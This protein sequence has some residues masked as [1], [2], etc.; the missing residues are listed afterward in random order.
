MKCGGRRGIRTLGGGS[1]TSSDYKSDAL[2]RS[3]SLPVQPGNRDFCLKIGLP[4]RGGP[5]LLC[6]IHKMRGCC[7]PSQQ[8]YLISLPLTFVTRHESLIITISGYCRTAAIFP[9]YCHFPALLPFSRITANFL[10]CCLRSSLRQFFALPTLS[11]GVIIISP[12]CHFHCIACGFSDR[13][14]LSVHRCRITFINHQT[15]RG[16]AVHQSK[17]IY[18]FVA[19]SV[20]GGGAHL[21]VEPLSLKMSGFR[22]LV[23]R[24][25]CVVK[26]N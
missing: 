22:T 2:S 15:G 11:L 3:A 16:P 18:L 13:C 21:L 17:K 14:Q 26:W 10:Y 5:F 6:T 25:V 23:G 7:N 19:A 20:F 24:E 1:S 9:H 12:F 4:L 8:N